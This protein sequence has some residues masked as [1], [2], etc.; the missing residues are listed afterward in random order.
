M[1]GGSAAS[2]ALHHR[3]PWRRD[4]RESGVVKVAQ[5]GA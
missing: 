4:A 2:P 3:Q 5:G 1:S